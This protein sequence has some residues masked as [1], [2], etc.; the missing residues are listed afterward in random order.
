MALDSN[1]VV[2]GVRDAKKK[3][4]S[5]SDREKTERCEW[6]FW[7]L[8]SKDA[9]IVLPSIAVAEVLRGISPS[10]HRKFLSELHKVFVIAPFDAK[11]ASIAGRLWHERLKKLPDH[12]D[13]KVK[14]KADLF[15]VASA[16]AANASVFY[17]DDNGARKI[18]ALSMT[19]R[20]L[21]SHKPTLFDLS[22]FEK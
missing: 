3:G 15:V 19:S 14:L 18:A 11:A 5:K 13:P 4:R 8:C 6:L 22:E 9:Q 1:V 16:K 7:D 20:G 2:W 17:S 10:K 12:P 21:P